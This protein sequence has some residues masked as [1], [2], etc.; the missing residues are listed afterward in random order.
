MYAV[1]ILFIIKLWVYTTAKL[2]SL[3]INIWNARVDVA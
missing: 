1:C 3:V 2:L